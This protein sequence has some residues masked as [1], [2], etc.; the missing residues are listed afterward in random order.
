MIFECIKINKGVQIINLR[1]MDFL[2]TSIQ[3]IFFI[4]IKYKIKLRERIN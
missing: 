3:Y 4:I 1:Q 2:E